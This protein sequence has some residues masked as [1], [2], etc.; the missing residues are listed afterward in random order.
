[1][2]LTRKNVTILLSATLISLSILSVS[3]LSYSGYLSSPKDR[4]KEVCANYDQQKNVITVTCN[5]TS[6]ELL[7]TIADDNVLRKETSEG[8]WFLNSSVVVSKDAV[9]TI[10]N[11]D[12][13]WIKINSE[14]RSS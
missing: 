10:N 3:I 6:S 14:G 7:D 9:L 5:L 13:K 2:N 4:P 11:K 12:V 8:I 1:M